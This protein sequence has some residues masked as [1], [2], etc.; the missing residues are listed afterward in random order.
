[1]KFI[2][3]LAI[4]LLSTIVQAQSIDVFSPSLYFRNAKQIGQPF[5]F[6]I[7]T[8]FIDIQDVIF[9]RF[10]LEFGYERENGKFY[11]SND[12]NINWT[13]LYFRDY[14]KDD[15]NIHN[16]TA[17]YIYDKIDYVRF[18]SSI[19]IDKSSMC[20]FM[21]DVHLKLKPLILKYSKSAK[22]QVMEVEFNWQRELKKW[23]MLKTFYELTFNYYNDSNAHPY[24]KIKIGW[25]FRIE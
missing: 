8:K 5:D 20:Y 18:G 21:A 10:L 1:M 23:F 19:L 6:L 22:K 3:V 11:Y 24:Y 9:K 4:L 13:G 12:Y 15:R 25:L 17:G 16:I 7:E 2:F 14:R